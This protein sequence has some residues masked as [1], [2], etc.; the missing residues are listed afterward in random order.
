[1]DKYDN[2]IVSEY[3]P[4]KVEDAKMIGASFLFWT[5]LY[6]VILYCPMPFKPAH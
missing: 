4:L 1:M 6:N 3:Y 5:T 2:M